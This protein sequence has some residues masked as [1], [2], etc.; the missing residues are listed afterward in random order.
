M[1][2]ILLGLYGH[3]FAK[4]FPDMFCQTWN[5]VVVVV[6][7]KG[8]L[9]KPLICQLAGIC[10][11]LGGNSVTEVFKSRNVLQVDLLNADR[12]P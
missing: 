5:P 1:K 8:E 2:G 7:R 6:V 12:A 10:N 11:S 3:E 9:R 4:A